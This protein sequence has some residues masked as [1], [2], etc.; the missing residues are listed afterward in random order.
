MSHTVAVVFT[1]V[2]P[3]IKFAVEFNY[4]MFVVSSS[5]STDNVN[6]IALYEDNS[7][8]LVSSIKPLHD[9]DVLRK[10]Q[11]ICK[12]NLPTALV[13]FFAITGVTPRVGLLSGYSFTELQPSSAT[14]DALK[15]HSVY[16][17]ILECA[18]SVALDIVTREKEKITATINTLNKKLEG[19]DR[20]LSKKRALDNPNTEDEPQA[21][22]I[23]SV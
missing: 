20:V 2:Q 15:L 4:K 23:K 12:D 8:V 11:T 9:N 6:T 21:K 3:T 22:R 17:K 5:Y 1:S 19:I 18:N 16:E 7:L 14:P 13:D 10:L